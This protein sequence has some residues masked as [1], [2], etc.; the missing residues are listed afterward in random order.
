MSDQPPPSTF[1]HAPLPATPTSPTP[2]TSSK[3]TWLM[4]GSSAPAGPGSPGRASSGHSS[5]ASSI[6]SVGKP[7]THQNAGGSISKASSK[8]HIFTKALPFGSGK[9]GSSTATATPASPGKIVAALTS[10]T[11]LTARAATFH[12]MPSSSSAAPAASTPVVYHSSSTSSLDS[13]TINSLNL[14]SS[15]KR[16]KFSPWHWKKPKTQSVVGTQ[17]LLAPSSSR[18]SSLGLLTPSESPVPADETNPQPLKRHQSVLAALDLSTTVQASNADMAAVATRASARKHR[19][20]KDKGKGKAATVS[21]ATGLGL[22]GAALAVDAADGSKRSRKQHNRPYR[23]SG[24]SDSDSP[25][26][27]TSIA[28]SAAVSAKRAPLLF[29]RKKKAHDSASGSRSSDRSRQ[30]GKSS[31]SSVSKQPVEVTVTR[32]SSI[33]SNRR[34]SISAPEY[35]RLAEIYGWNLS[36]EGRPSAANVNKSNTELPLA[37]FSTVLAPLPAAMTAMLGSPTMRNRQPAK[38][39]PQTASP[40][41]GSAAPSSVP[42]PASATA[43]DDSD[44]YFAYRPSA[45]PPHSVEQPSHRPVFTKH[46]LSA[47]EPGASL[48][49]QPTAQKLSPNLG[50]SHR[51]GP[52]SQPRV[53]PP[54]KSHSLPVPGRHTDT[55]DEPSAMAASP[56]ADGTASILTNTTEGDWVSEEGSPSLQTVAVSP[57]GT[58]EYSTTLKRSNTLLRGRSMMHRASFRQKH[59]KY[60]HMGA[61]RSVSR[62][63]ISDLAATTSATEQTDGSDSKSETRVETSAAAGAAAPAIL[64]RD[65]HLSDHS[66]TSSHSRSSKAKSKRRT[67]QRPPSLLSL[68]HRLHQPRP[69]N[70]L[71]ASTSCLSPPAPPTQEPSIVSYPLSPTTRERYM[72]QAADIPVPPVPTRKYYYR[73]YGSAVS[74]RSSQYD[75]MSPVSSSA[76]GDFASG[77]FHSDA[78]PHSPTSDG[79]PMRRMSLASAATTAMSPLLSPTRMSAPPL[80]QLTHNDDTAGDNAGKDTSAQIEKM[81]PSQLSAPWTIPD[82]FAKLHEQ[83]L[84]DVLPHDLPF[85]VIEFE[86]IDFSL[87]REHNLAKQGSA[88]PAAEPLTEAQKMSLSRN[89]DQSVVLP[90]LP[91]IALAAPLDEPTDA[92]ASPAAPAAQP[93]QEQQPQSPFDMTALLVNVFDEPDTESNIEYGLPAKPASATLASLSKSASATPAQSAPNSGAATPVKSSRPSGAAGSTTGGENGSL[94]GT[95]AVSVA[96][97]QGP[98]SAAQNQAHDDEVIIMSA[99]CFKLVEKLT[100]DVDYAFLSDFFLVYR[101][102]MTPLQLARLITLRIRFAL[103]WPE[104]TD[105]KRVIRFRCFIFLRYWLTEFFAQDFGA[106]KRLRRY[107]AKVLKTMTHM[108]VLTRGAEMDRRMVKTVKRL[109]RSMTDEYMRSNPA[110]NA[111]SAPPV[112]ALPTEEERVGLAE[113]K[114]T[115][116]T[117]AEAAAAAAAATVPTPAP[118]SP[119]DDSEPALPSPSPTADTFSDAR[120]SKYTTRSEE[121][122]STFVSNNSNMPPMPPRKR[123]SLPNIRTPSMFSSAKPASS[124]KQQQQLGQSPLQEELSTSPEVQPP[125]PLTQNTFLLP[126]AGLLG[127]YAPRRG[128]RS[129]LSVSYTSESIAAEATDTA[130]GTDS[131]AAQQAHRHRSMASSYRSTAPRLS[132][133]SSSLA[134]QNEYL[135]NV[136]SSPASYQSSSAD[137]GFRSSYQRSSVAYSSSHG[138]RSGTGDDALTRSNSQTSSVSPFNR[139][140]ARQS[141]TPGS[142]SVDDD[143]DAIYRLAQQI[144][145]TATSTNPFL[146]QDDSS[147]H[148]DMS[149]GGTHMSRSPPTDSYNHRHSVT[150]GNSGTAVGDMSP[151]PSPFTAR[152]LEKDSPRDSGSID[153][154]TDHL[155]VPSHEALHDS[156]LSPPIASPRSTMTFDPHHSHHSNGH[157]PRGR[158]KKAHERE[159]DVK[160]AALVKVAMSRIKK[161]VT[162]IWSPGQAPPHGS[163]Q[164]VLAE[165]DNA[166]YADDDASDW[167]EEPVSTRSDGPNAS[168]ELVGADGGD[169]TRTAGGSGRGSKRLRKKAND[170]PSGATGRDDDSD[171]E[172]AGGDKDGD[173][174]DAPAAGQPNG[175]FGGPKRLSL[176]SITRRSRSQTQSVKLRPAEVPFLL[177]ANSTELGRYLSLLEQVAIRRV[178]WTE[179]L[180]IAVGRHEYLKKM[181]KRGSIGGAWNATGTEEENADNAKYGI[182]GVI[183]RFNMTSQWVATQ[184]VTVNDLGTRV[185]VVEKFIKIAQICQHYHNYSTLMAI[186]LALQSPAIDRLKR[187]WARVSPDKRAQLKE[188][189]ALTSPF[190]NFRSLRDAM[191]ETPSGGVPFLGI[192]LSDLV[193]NNELP[194]TLPT[195]PAHSVIA[196]SIVS[197]ASTVGTGGGDD[198]QAAWYEEFAGLKTLVNWHKYRM[199]ARVVKQFKTFLDGPS[200]ATQQWTF[201]DEYWH[202]LYMQQHV[203]DSADVAKLSLKCERRTSQTRRKQTA[204]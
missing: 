186:T 43:D 102:F 181:G 110:A 120:M 48:L 10:P 151:T 59:R 26:A 9:A 107:M 136:P 94:V 33:S 203:L 53:S 51:R 78:A 5:D 168:G 188:M 55:A 62:R 121:V 87:L 88:N 199:I 56:S 187:T 135:H 174:A 29:G 169:I 83:Y 25:L 123:L 36:R 138:F 63:P 95:T 72:K 96:S 173:E 157:E 70:N 178:K 180:D 163:D 54:V 155:A 1:I 45:S 23:R 140:L 176:V 162:Q 149:P 161:M 103:P 7:K 115:A 196:P 71:P 42:I 113:E 100:T 146:R 111:A 8:L 41:L 137:Y 201:G 182:K 194:A 20:G 198:D 6:H 108:R 74:P 132:Y 128:H 30:S 81:M 57:G 44:S 93:N 40:L 77:H 150:S 139:A 124:S 2:S 97:G 60:N 15:A 192:Y 64:S 22:A 116:E 119:P 82:D 172:D 158:K 193:F 52:D 19:K 18:P 117:A 106:D 114:P 50:R 86:H 159:K 170:E 69:F 75:L 101:L 32:V 145:A 67:R 76:P 3:R 68:D 90:D 104:D 148:R 49:A 184:I 61:R 46:I 12:N 73:Y 165:E 143:D 130:P 141:A 167:D 179:L 177:K 152:N 189:V 154:Q 202:C 89:A 27:S 14:Q 80:A 85:R 4:G 91:G 109:W 166:N 153:L 164:A 84:R 17:L 125:S 11:A 175:I 24:Y 92:T 13:V 127:S 197:G 185:K 35:Q 28:D 131:E 134:H 66:A 16:S 147:Y 195:S 171:K 98:A 190:H 112:P 105:E 47:L 21:A 99:S 144:D 122:V 142:T 58:E 34:H 118:S 129:R 39:Q 126:S 204:A 191:A 156:P 65:T 133:G 160:V 38:R 183:D 37:D 200:Y 31:D 79:D